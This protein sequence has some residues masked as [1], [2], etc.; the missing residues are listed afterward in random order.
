[1]NA[2]RAA[3]V[4][5][6]LAPSVS[7]ADPKTHTVDATASE[8]V[9]L[10]YKAG[11]ASGLAHDHVIA[12][13]DFTGTLTY[14]PK[15]PAATQISL[16]IQAASLVADLPALTKKHGLTSSPSESDRK[17]IEETLKGEDQL[18]VKKFPTISFKSKS[19]QVVEGVLHISG[20]FTLH[21][22]SKTV[23]LPVTIASE[24]SGALRGKGTFTVRQSDFGYEPYSAFLGAV[25]VK[26]RVR[27]TVDL[28]TK[29]EEKKEKKKEKKK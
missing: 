13:K 9:V 14:D 3:L 22:K 7:R 29:V 27:I 23:T 19:A 17:S 4:C 15:D 24:K 28:V 5:L 12:A 2:T 11:L 25:K 16:T 8:V 20:T 26:D 18:D 10:V 21:G 6:L 1:M